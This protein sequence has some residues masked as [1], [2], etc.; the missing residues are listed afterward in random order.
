MDSGICPGGDFMIPCHA[1]I[2][3][4]RSVVLGNDIRGHFGKMERQSRGKATAIID[5]NYK[6]D[7]LKA[8]SKKV[9]FGQTFEENENFHHFNTLR[10]SETGEERAGPPYPWTHR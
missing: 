1:M 4:N 2:I 7:G 3:R 6:L 8:L 9:T 5:C 10:S